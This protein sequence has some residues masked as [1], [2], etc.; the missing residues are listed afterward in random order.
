MKDEDKAQAQLISELR[1]IRRR[2]AEF[3][4]GQVRYK[5]FLDEYE[6]SVME[7]FDL[8]FNAPDMFVSVDAQTEKVLHC[9]W[10]V[11]AA[12][13]YCKA[14]IIGDSIFKLYDRDCL[15]SAKELFRITAETGEI[16]DAEQ[17]LR[18]RDGR[19]IDVSLN[20]AAVRDEKDNLTSARFVWRDIT[21]RAVEVGDLRSENR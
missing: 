15:E 16:H 3:E 17:T 1:Q 6:E 5:Q 12:L 2:V 9:N 10:D 7:Y 13:G 8:Y 4:Q 19:K 20:A 14:E 21:R 11:I 18:T